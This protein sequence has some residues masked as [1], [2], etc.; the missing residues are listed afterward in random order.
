MSNAPTNTLPNPTVTVK[1]NTDAFNA[2][3]MFTEAKAEIKRLEAL[4]K[5]AEATIREALG[6]ATTGTFNGQT[7]VKVAARTTTKV[8]ATVLKEAFP[9]AYEGAKYSSSF[10]FLQ[11]L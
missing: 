10:T 9:E 7:V 6:D 5:E 8:S 2:C 11:T 4:Q 3:K 1:I